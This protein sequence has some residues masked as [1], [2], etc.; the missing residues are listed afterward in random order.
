VRAGALA[1]ARTLD[2]AVT[3]VPVD[4]FVDYD[5]RY[6]PSAARLNAL[7]SGIILVEGDAAASITAEAAARL[8]ADNAL[9]ARLDAEEALSVSFDSRLD[10]EEA[11]S[12][13]FDTRLDVLEPVA[14]AN[15]VTSLPGSPSDFQVVSYEADATNGVYWRLM[16]VPTQP[17]GKR[18]VYIGGNPL[19]DEIL[20]QQTRAN[21][22]YGDLTT[23][24][25]QVTVPLAGDYE[26]HAGA[27]GFISA[28]GNSIL[29]ASLKLG[30]AA[31]S[32]NDV[33]SW[34]GTAGIT[35]ATAQGNA[36]AAQIRR[37]LAA[38]DVV[39]MQYK[40][41]AG[42]GAWLNRWLKVLPVRVG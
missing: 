42:T 25:P 37:T 38:S 35:P 15:V 21:V 23:A 26:L 40:A 29:A 41:S 27:L 19:S 3:W 33:V 36:G 24:G 5:P 10:A 13:S 11:L 12:T 28:T 14:P 30:A 22:A 6:G 34:Q 9:D 8:A 32:D 39:K 16:Y 20:T 2:Q 31:A 18:W 4:P 7:R 17:A 1:S